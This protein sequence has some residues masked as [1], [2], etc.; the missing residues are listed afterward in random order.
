MLCQ[1]LLYSKMTQS[2]IHIH[3][4]SQFFFFFFFLLFVRAAPVA[5]ES[6]RLGVPS[7]Q[8]LPVYATATQ[9]QRIWAASATYTEAYGNPGSLAPLSEARD[10]TGILMDTSRVHNC[11]V[12]MGTPLFL[13]SSSFILEV[14]NRIPLFSAVTSPLTLLPAFSFFFFFLKDLWDYIKP[15]Q[16]IQDNI[17]V[18]SFLT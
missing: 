12:T 11:W 9:H 17:P 18:W 2:Y 5:Y 4:L 6:S 14:I 1:F 3:S 7:N 8:Q 10:Q 13:I 16:I 15:V